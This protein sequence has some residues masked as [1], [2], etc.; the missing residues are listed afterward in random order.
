[1]LLAILRHLAAHLT[2]Y[3]L[4]ICFTLQVILTL[5]Q[6]TD[7]NGTWWLLAREM[8]NSCLARTSF[9]MS[10]LASTR[11]TSYIHRLACI[12]A[13]HQDHTEDYYCY[14]CGISCSHVLLR[15]QVG[16][17]HF[18]TSKDRTIMIGI[19]LVVAP[20]WAC[21]FDFQTPKWKIK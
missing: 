12:S 13:C 14:H 9:Y 11:S 6:R 1:M 5:S 20:N 3:F 15:A 7:V 16:M 10:Q 19:N 17:A 18:H 4:P 21:H 2:S 8:M